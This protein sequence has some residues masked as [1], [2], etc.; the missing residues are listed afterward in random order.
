MTIYV[1]S[2]VKSFGND[3]CLSLVHLVSSYLVRGSHKT[4]SFGQEAREVA[5]Q[6]S[7]QNA[8][9]I[10]PQKSLEL[11]RAGTGKL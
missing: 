2:T 8:V 5:T 6:E 11:D 4:H 7:L 9:S 3:Y 10:R 1:P